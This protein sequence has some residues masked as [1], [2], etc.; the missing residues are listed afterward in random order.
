MT[1]KQSTL[2][3]I[4]DSERQLLLDAEHRYGDYYHHARESSIFLSRCIAS[5]DHDRMMFARFFSLVKKHH[6]LALLSV[7]RLHR[8]QASMNLRQVIEA[9]CA[10]AFAIAN[11]ELEHFAEAD[12][13]GILDPSQDLTKKRYRWLDQNYPD[14]SKAMRAKKDRINSY[15]AHANI[16]NSGNIFE[17]NPTGDAIAAPFFD[18]ED[19]YHVKTDLWLMAST[20]IELMDWFYGVNQGRDVIQFIPKFVGTL[21]HVA[22]DSDTLL[23]EMKSSARFQR[24]LQKLEGKA[25]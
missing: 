8:V 19:G 16:L 25:E 14:Q 22:Q 13:Q 7:L 6:M 24:T 4:I 17:I 18:V 9:G 23:A 1:L 2:E 12:T 3:E 10:A 5:V 21:Q 20:A 11:P 15:S